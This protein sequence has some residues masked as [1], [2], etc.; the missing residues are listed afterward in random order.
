MLA[1]GHCPF[2]EA[3]FC[4]FNGKRNSPRRCASHNRRNT[5]TIN[6]QVHL[7]DGTKS[8]DTMCG[9]K[10]QGKLTKKRRKISAAQK[11]K[12]KQARREQV[13]ITKFLFGRTSPVCLAALT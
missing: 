7:E 12:A 1:R 4:M 3:G 9:S 2:Q 10:T 6:T 8:T 11:E 13:A 5:M